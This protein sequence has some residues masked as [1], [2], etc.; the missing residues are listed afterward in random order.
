MLKTVIMYEDGT[1]MLKN[2]NPVIIGNTNQY[3]LDSLLIAKKNIIKEIIDK[4][5]ECWY[6]KGVPDIG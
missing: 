3:I 6:A 2:E 1:C 5:M 4:T